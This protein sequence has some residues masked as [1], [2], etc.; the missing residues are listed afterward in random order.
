MRRARLEEWAGDAS[1]RNVGAWLKV[2]SVDSRHA[3]CFMTV[4]RKPKLW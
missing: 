2:A 1:V 4:I 3:W